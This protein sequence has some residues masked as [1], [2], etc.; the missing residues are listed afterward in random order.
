MH[1][2]ANGRLA[3]ID[4]K[5]AG[6]GM[7]GSLP[8]RDYQRRVEARRLGRDGPVGRNIESGNSE[9][10]HHLRVHAHL[11]ATRESPKW[12][13]MHHYSE[14]GNGDYERREFTDGMKMLRHIARH[15]HV[16]GFEGEEEKESK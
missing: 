12:V 5:Q 15:A 7:P 9:E 3:G 10:L 13:V 6:V 16:P 4:T 14:D 2:S 1:L 11:D 8:Y